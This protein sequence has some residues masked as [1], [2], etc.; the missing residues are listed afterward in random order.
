MMP[1][2]DGWSVLSALK[3][4]PELTEIPVLMVTVVQ[5]KGLA[6]SLGA[7][8]YLTKPVEWSRLKRSLDRYRPQACPGCALVVEADV[9]S[10]RELRRLLD[11][12]G[13]TATEV[14]DIPAAKRH[15]QEAASPPGLVLVAVQPPGDEAFAL[16][17]AL[18]QQPEW[19]NVPVVAIAGPQIGA[20]EFGRLRDQVR[21]ILPAEADLPAE[22][23][24]E[25]RRL[26]ARCSTP[27]QEAEGE[28]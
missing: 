16:I 6:F 17:Q 23:A 4:D 22:L 11:A 19:R 28:G 25:L 5:E 15:L 2:M 24:A 27:T 12:E 9:A 26:A 3:A 13:W 20:E 7:A 8:D 14:A 10:R 21:R 1:Q 18:H